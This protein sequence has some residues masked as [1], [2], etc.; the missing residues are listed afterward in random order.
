MEI[1]KDG[2]SGSYM[3]SHQLDAFNDFVH[4]GL[5][6]IIDREPEI[7]TENGNIKIGHVMVDT[8]KFTDSDRVTRNLY[9]NEARDRNITYAGTIYVNATV[10]KPNEQVLELNKIAIG[11]LPIMLQSS[12]CNLSEHNKVEQKECENDPGGYFIIKGKERTLIGQLRPVYNRVYVYPQSDKFTHMAEMRSMHANGTSVL[13]QA[14]INSKMETFFSLPYLNIKE[15]IQAGAV[16]KALGISR[17]TVET[18]V[19]VSEKILNT[20]LCQYDEYKTAGDVETMIAKSLTDKDEDFVRSIL[21]NEIFCHIGF[22]THTKTFNHLAYMLKRI[23]DTVEKKASITDKDDLAN[24]RID[25]TS[26]LIGFL[27]QGLFKQL[28]KNIATKVCEKKNPDYMNIIKNSSNITHR[29]NMCFMTG[30]WDIQKN[31]S[32]MRV[33]VSQ[34]LSRQNYKAAISHGRRI[35]LPIGNKG[36]NIE[37]RRL[38][39]SHF[40]FVCPYE[41]PEGPTVGIVLNLAMTAKVALE[42]SNADLIETFKRFKLISQDMSKKNVI[43]LNGTIIGATDNMHAFYVEFEKYRKSDSIDGSVSIV[44][45]IDSNEIHILSDHGRLIRPVFQVEKN[46]INFYEN[47]RKTFQE[48]LD[49]NDIVYRSP[50][51]LQQSTIAMTPEDLKKNKCDYAEICP[52]VVMMGISAIDIPFPNHSQSPRIAYQA[53]MGKQAIGMP[54]LAYQHRYDTTLHVLDTPQSPITQTE[55][56]NV[57]KFN[58]MSHGCMPIV[59]IMTYTG[60]NQEDSII[61]NK[62][63]IE[64]GLFVSTTYKTIVEEAKKRGN[65]DFETICTPKYEYRRREYDYSHLGED[66]IVKPKSDS[67]EAKDG[68]KS[69]SRYVKKGDV[70][71]GKTMNKMVKKDDKREIE[72]T[73]TSVVIKQGEEGYID[74]VVDTV[75]NDG[76]RVVKVR[77]RIQRIPEIGDKFASSCAQKGTCGM[78]YSQEDMPFDKDGISPDLIMNPHAIPSRMTINMLLDMC[79]NLI[80]CKEGKRYISTAFARQNISQELEDIMKSHGWS[81]YSS[82]LYSGMTGRK[83]PSKIFM[84]PAF[85]QRLKHLVSGK[86]HSRM[87]GP[88]DTLTHQPVAGRAKDGGL[89]FG[90]M[91]RDAMVAQGC[92]RVLKECLFDKS[93][94]YSTAVCKTCGT[95]PHDSK[96]CHKC[97][98]NQI[99]LKNMPFATKLLYQELMA[100]GIKITFE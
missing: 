98:D 82:T 55:V 8:P 95:I 72:V 65:S 13:I 78:I 38:H 70:I 52:A 89:R 39:S 84:A 57:V 32:F 96:Y 62:S 49:S 33:G 53:C 99:E 54:S 66:G 80:G 51:E 58:E 4:N 76:V 93:D 42:I 22:L 43:L 21:E 94:K 1:I 56:L 5:Q 19:K 40:G 64:R 90:E 69:D 59:A 50:W 11:E 9:P 71:I 48:G 41:T 20:I 37:M 45:L 46:K 88:L 60:F 12:I 74:S 92:S 36:K 75:T 14:K 23:S 10:T 16:F 15:Y 83:I 7:K 68:L 79:Y 47:N 44:K 86:I 100:I 61:L 18:T 25:T 17:E 77:I 85:Y 31:A 81:S 67:S 87:C 28:V 73:D 3:V 26:S 24:K 2:I 27:F 63:S 97:K 6:Q 30:N 29:L 34:V 91:E 35:M